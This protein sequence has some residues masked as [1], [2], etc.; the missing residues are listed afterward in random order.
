MK[1]PGTSI[2]LAPAASL[3]LVD[4]HNQETHAMSSLLAVLNLPPLPPQAFR[5][6][7]RRVPRKPVAAAATADVLET[8]LV[9]D[10]GAR[11][12]DRE[13]D[14]KEIAAFMAGS[15]GRLDKPAAPADLAP[16]KP[17]TT[18]PA[19]EPAPPAGSS[20][21]IPVSLSI[22]VGKKFKYV[23]I[24]KLKIEGELKFEDA[25]QAGVVKTADVIGVSIDKRKLA[26][27]KKVEIDLAKLKELLLGQVHEENKN[28]TFKVDPKL[29]CKV[30]PGELSVALGITVSTDHYTGSAKFVAVAKESGKDWEFASVQVAPFGAQFKDKPVELNGVKGKVS[31]KLAV[32]V[33]IKP[34]WG[35]IGVDVATRVGRPVLTAA[36][37]ALTAEAAIVA[38][39]V[40]GAA[41]TVFAYAKSVSEWRDVRDCALAAEKGWMSFRAGFASAYG[42]KW[43]G[44]GVAELRKQGAAAAKALLDARLATSRKRA[45]AEHGALPAGFDAEWRATMKEVAMKNPDGLGMWIQKNFRRQIFD[46]FFQAYAQAHSDDYMF[47]QNARA[48]RTL[49]G[50]GR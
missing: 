40:A 28:A 15:T 34:E 32:G 50:V 33:V 6:L 21:Q 10:K 43:A 13:V 37:E 46:G 24:E 16:A 9:E 5:P 23:E 41:A 30:G 25:G 17:P 8:E 48:L 49:L 3:G 27:A 18:V 1:R 4:N 14:E 44:G 35:A 20:L 39:F 26:P 31:G 7:L 42:L 12:V 19:A 29:E 38:G 36:A 11:W 47:E 22:K 45:L 2:A